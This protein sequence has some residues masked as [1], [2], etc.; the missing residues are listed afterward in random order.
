MMTESNRLRS[1]I[2]PIGIA[3]WFAFISPSWAGDFTAKPTFKI[4]DPA[5]AIWPIS[6]IQGYSPMP[7]P[8][9]RPAL[10]R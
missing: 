1:L 10:A 4:G 9:G 8:F 7:G 5:P 3:A 2:G 6:W